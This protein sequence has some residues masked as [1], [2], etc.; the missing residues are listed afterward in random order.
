MGSG[1]TKKPKQPESAIDDILYKQR[2]SD[3]IKQD[4]NDLMNNPLCQQLKVLDKQDQMNLRGK[5][6]IAQAGEEC[7]ICASSYTL[8]DERILPCKHKFH[9]QCLDDWFE[10]QSTNYYSIKTC[11]ICRAIND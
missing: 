6:D 2:T 1:N 4:L 5:Q 3:E 9:G 10:H 11:P 7:I 8:L